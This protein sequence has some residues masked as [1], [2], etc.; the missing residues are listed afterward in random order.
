MANSNTISASIAAT[1]LG[2][3]FPGSATVQ[4]TPAGSDGIK[5]N[6]SIATSATQI[7]VSAT[8]AYVMIIN[9][10]ATNY[11]NVSFENT[12]AVTPQKLLPGGFCIISPGTNPVWAKA[13]TAAVEVTVVSI[14]L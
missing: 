3:Q 2:Q 7:T 1:I 11:V 9:N 5:N 10:D 6:V 12:A 14:P 8:P 13:N 4:T